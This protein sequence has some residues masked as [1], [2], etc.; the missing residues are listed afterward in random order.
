MGFNCLRDLRI[1]DLE[2]F[3]TAAQLKNLSKAALF[4]HIRQSAASAAI[5]RVETAFG[6]SLCKHER[7]QFK[8]TSEGTLL[9]PRAENWLTTLRETVAT[10]D[11][12]PLRIVTSHAIAQVF[13]S[14]I[15]EHE[16]IDIKLMRPDKA[17]T[18]ILKDEADV[19]IVLDNANWDGLITKE[20]A[21]GSF[22]LYSRNQMIQPCPVL[23]PEDQI[24]VLT[25]Q[26]RWQETFQ[27]PL[28]IKAR[29][30]SWSLIASV[31]IEKDEVGLLPD[32]LGKKSGLHPVTFQP[33][34]SHYRLLALFHKRSHR[35]NLRLD[36]LIEHLKQ[37]F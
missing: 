21:T 26:E 6:K 14:H 5:T 35:L 28:P 11:L 23:L 15:L 17:Y 36:K 7:R 16:V 27:S 37:S 1:A 2:L 18:A 31:C 19:A 4:H 33:K 20:I 29:L 12:A 25:F 32:F 8:L 30:P 24:E 13:I 10:Q 9:L 22:Q 3:I 34:S